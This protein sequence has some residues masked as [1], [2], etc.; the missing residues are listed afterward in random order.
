MYGYI[1]EVH[2]LHAAEEVVRAG[3]V[4]FVHQEVRAHVSPVSPFIDWSALVGLFV[5]LLGF[6]FVG[7][8]AASGIC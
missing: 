7:V 2:L 5:C 8:C 1:M 4:S 3:V 6:C